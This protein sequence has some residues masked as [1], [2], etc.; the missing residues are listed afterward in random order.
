MRSGLAAM[1]GGVDIPGSAGVTV[2]M[3][4]PHFLFD[5]IQAQGR[6][7]P[8]AGDQVSVYRPASIVC[9]VIV[10]S[11]VIRAK[12]A[13]GHKLTIRF[14]ARDSGCSR[15]DCLD[16]ASPLTRTAPAFKN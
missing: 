5:L 9:T 1:A 6:T 13:T 10:H 2:D 14:R 7:A 3:G 15:V 16:M 12:A 4:L 8:R 11:T